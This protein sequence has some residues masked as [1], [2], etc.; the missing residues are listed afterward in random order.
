LWSAQEPEQRIAL[1]YRAYKELGLVSESKRD[2]HIALLHLFRK[3]KKTPEQLA[4]WYQLGATFPDKL[5]Q[6]FYSGL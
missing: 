6:D 3:W 2:A 4:A 1:T 5:F